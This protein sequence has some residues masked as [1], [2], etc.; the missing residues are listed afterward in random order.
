LPNTGSFHLQTSKEKPMTRNLMYFIPSLFVFILCQNGI[1]SEIQE[2]G[3]GI[4]LPKGV[5]SK[6]IIDLISPRTDASLAT[7]VGMKKWPYRRNAYIAIVCLAPDRKEYETDT[8]YSNGRPCCHAGYGGFNASKNP[9]T[10]FIGMI[11]YQKELKLV[12]LHDGPLAVYTNWENSNIEPS[13][14]EKTDSVYPGIYDKF[15][16]ANY[17]VSDNQTAFGI[18][19]AWRVMYAGGGGLF[20]GLML[21]VVKENKIINIFS[22]PIEE[23][24]LSGSGPE[25]KSSWETVNVLMILPHK[26]SDYYDIQVKEK[27]GKWNKIFKWNAETNRYQPVN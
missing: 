17:K 21:F 3:F 14:I 25:D 15:D 8:S 24:G 11:E 1:S 2:N 18:R 19:V 6:E 4:L 16:F 7:L 22:E 9:S 27:G 12:A 13:D 20:Y 23:S 26:T 10:V 5:T